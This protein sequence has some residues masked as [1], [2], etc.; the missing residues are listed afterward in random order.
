[1]ND[2]IYTPSDDD[3]ATDADL[4]EAER[5]YDEATTE[6]WHDHLAEMAMAAA[7][8]DDMGDLY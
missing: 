8:F 1:M 5:A 4:E 3:M 6:A 2:E 7:E